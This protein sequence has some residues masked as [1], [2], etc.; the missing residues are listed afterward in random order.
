M[1]TGHIFPALCYLPPFPHPRALKAASFYCPPPQ[2]VL[3]K[4]RS[5]CKVPMKD[6]RPPGRTHLEVQ[7]AQLCPGTQTEAT[8][9]QPLLPLRPW[10]LQAQHFRPAPSWSRVPGTLIPK[11]HSQVTEGQTFAMSSALQSVP[12]GGGAGPECRRGYSY[13]SALHK[14]PRRVPETSRPLP[15]NL[16]L[17]AIAWIKTERAAPCQDFWWTLLK[18][19]TQ[20]TEPRGHPLP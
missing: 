17:L 10:P 12:R 5:E 7:E 4:T 14:R 9:D 1:P 2:S 16:C 6:L 18:T 8:A 3:K 13:P 15:S 11:S 19:G 20:K